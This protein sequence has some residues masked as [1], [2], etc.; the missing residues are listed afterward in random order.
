MSSG[1]WT[2]T[3]GGAKVTVSASGVGA[4]IAVGY[5][6]T[7]PHQASEAVSG[8]AT[9]LAI[10]VGSLVAIVAAVVVLKLR[11]HSRT[12]APA[13]SRPPVSLLRAHPNAI[14]VRAALEIGRASG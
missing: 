11:R 4:L 6:L 7:H 10:T 9:I 3:N 8:V 13:G 14:P 5:A 1:T 2:T 12:A